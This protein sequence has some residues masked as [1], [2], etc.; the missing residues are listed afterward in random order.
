MTFGLT[1]KPD[2]AGGAQR[3]IGQRRA[4]P[5][6]QGPEGCNCVGAPHAPQ[7]IR[8]TVL[9]GNVQVAAHLR[10][11]GHGVQQGTADA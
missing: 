4:D 7:D 10:H 2:Q 5:A 3:G 1:G 8:M 6:G 11:L 9:N